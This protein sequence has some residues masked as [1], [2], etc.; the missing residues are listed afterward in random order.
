MIPRFYPRVQVKA[1]ASIIGCGFTGNGTVLDVTVPGCLIESRLP[2]RKGDSLT[3]R[4]TI[5][6]VRATFLVARA[7]VRWVDGLRFGV[8]FIEMQSKERVRFNATV[9]RLLQQQGPLPDN[10]LDSDSVTSRTA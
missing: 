1:S 8:E 5:P 6:Q 9:D 4:V 2:V 10:L 3:L 7:V